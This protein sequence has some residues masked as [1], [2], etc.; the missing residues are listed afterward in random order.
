MIDRII[1]ELGFDREKP[2]YFEEHR[3]ATPTSRAGKKAVILIGGTC[4]A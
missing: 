4:P 3:I 1:R 2:S